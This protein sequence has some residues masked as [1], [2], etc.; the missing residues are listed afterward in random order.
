MQRAAIIAHCADMTRRLGRRVSLDEAA[1]E[2]IPI[3]AEMWRHNFE[4]QT[5]A[6]SL[7]ICPSDANPGNA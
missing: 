7:G 4:K 5:V 2:W 6:R 3:Y 1:R